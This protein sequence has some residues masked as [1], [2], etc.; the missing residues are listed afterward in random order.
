[1]ENHKQKGMKTGGTP[2][3]LGKPDF[4]HPAV[5]PFFDDRYASKTQVWGDAATSR[6]AD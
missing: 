5:S 4:S 2:M 6:L 3:T 1:M